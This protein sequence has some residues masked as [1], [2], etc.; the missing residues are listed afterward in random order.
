MSCICRDA[1]DIRGQPVKGEMQGGNSQPGQRRCSHRL[2]HQAGPDTHAQGSVERQP[3]CCQGNHNYNT[4]N[5]N[6]IC[7][8]LCIFFKTSFHYASQ[9]V[10]NEIANISASI[11]A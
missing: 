2:S 1:T 9:R 7:Y 6:F 5:N 10:K 11:S 4:W 8:E 3:D